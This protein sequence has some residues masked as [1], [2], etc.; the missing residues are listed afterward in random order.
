MVFSHEH[1]RHIVKVITKISQTLFCLLH[2]K[3]HK[4][5]VHNPSYFCEFLFWFM[6]FEWMQTFCPSTTLKWLGYGVVELLIIEL[7]LMWKLSNTRCGDYLIFFE[8][9]S[10]IVGYDYFNQKFLM[11]ILFR[12]IFWNKNVL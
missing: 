3:L 4:I 1:F 6:N 5:V 11:I 12:W 2:S 7:I 9:L 10:Y 8:N